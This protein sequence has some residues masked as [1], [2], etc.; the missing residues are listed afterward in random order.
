VEHGGGG[1]GN[2]QSGREPGIV[3][4]HTVR[5]SCAAAPRGPF[6]RSRYLNR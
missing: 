5:S 4:P 1:Y 2:R 6:G 3:V